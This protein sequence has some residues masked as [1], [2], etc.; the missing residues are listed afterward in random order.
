MTDPVKEREI[1]LEKYIRDAIQQ[2]RD[3][4]GWSNNDMASALVIVDD[5]GQPPHV[6]ASITEVPDP[7]V[8]PREAR[9]IVFANL[10]NAVN[11]VQKALCTKPL[12]NKVSEAFRAVDIRWLH[13][14]FKKPGGGEYTIM[15][16]C[17]D[18]SL[19]CM[20][21]KTGCKRDIPR[22]EVG[23][24]IA[25]SGLTTKDGQFISP[26]ASKAVMDAIKELEYGEEY[27]RWRAYW[28]NRTKGDETNIG[29]TFNDGTVCGT[30][31]GGNM[32]GPYQGGKGHIYVKSFADG[33][34][35]KRKINGPDDPAAYVIDDTGNPRRIFE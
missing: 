17:M 9:G 14:T 23:K 5:F 27:K 24:A 12:A 11:F 13:G 21:T 1:V 22:E 33:K 18:S 6:C 7:S 20:N 4:N 2:C 26:T 35:I 31:L 25:Q 34:V 30:F 16:S 28:P 19:R 32:K 29:R 10:N 3:D 15:G 8:E